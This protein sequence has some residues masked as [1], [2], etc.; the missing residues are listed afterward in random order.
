VMDFLFLLKL[1][2]HR[3]FSRLKEKIFKFFC[4]VDW[5][6][7]A[8]TMPIFVVYKN[9]K[10][11]RAHTHTHTHNDTSTIHKR[12]VPRALRRQFRRLRQFR[13]FWCVTKTR[14]SE[15]GAGVAAGPSWCFLFFY[16][17]VSWLS[18]AWRL[19]QNKSNADDST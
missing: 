17:C 19:K 5:V 2:F 6:W 15:R 13:G 1:C 9:K 12:I 18:S 11:A 4:V 7:V 3:A 14:E 16:V 10:F 8:K